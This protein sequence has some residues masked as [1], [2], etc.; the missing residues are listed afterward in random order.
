MVKGN[1]IDTLAIIAMF[2]SYLLTDISKIS[3][4]DIPVEEREKVFNTNFFYY[5]ITLNG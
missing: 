3:E 1:Q 5:N 4:I 2:K